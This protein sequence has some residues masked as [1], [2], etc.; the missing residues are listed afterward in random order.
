MLTIKNWQ[1]L[2]QQEQQRCLIR[3]VQK[4]PIKNTVLNLIK[5][6]QTD[7]DKALFELTQKLDG[8]NLSSLQLTSEQIKAAKITQNALTAINQAIETITKYHQSLLPESKTISTAPGINI[9]TIYRPI[10]KVGLY[11]PAGN[12]T[13]LVSSVLMQAIPAR[14]AGCPIKVLCTPADACGEINPHLLVAARLC[15]IKTIYALGGAQA[16]AAMAYGTETVTKVDKLFGPGN[17][18]VT[19]AKTL[20]ASDP[21]GAAIDMPAGPSEVMVVADKQAN[22]AFVA[23]DLL[24]QAE[25]GVDSQVYLLCDDRNFA[26]KV[27]QEL[28][29]QVLNLS[30]T[31]IISQALTNSLIILCSDLEEQVKIINTYA[32]EHLIINRTDARNWVAKINTAGTIFLGPWAAETMGDYISGSNHVLPTNGFA[33]NHNGLSTIDFLTRFTIQTITQDGIKNLGTAA[34]TL[35]QIEGLDAHAN[36]VQI[37]LNSLEI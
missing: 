25:H 1:E 37:R 28:E 8:A 15:G 35:A 31:N 20:V 9:D 23:A 6:V 7:G 33:R 18:Y 17:S 13:P 30:R 14:I 27:N 5:Q 16:I 22:P 36:A 3:P 26:L 10:Q 21:Q 4:T 34:I 11:V 19:V 29:Q 32:P 24:A 2:S 12:K